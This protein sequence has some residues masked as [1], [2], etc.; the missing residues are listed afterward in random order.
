MIH[1]YKAMVHITST[2][3]CPIIIKFLKCKIG[4][5]RIVQQIMVNI[6][7][8]RPRSESTGFIIHHRKRWKLSMRITDLFIHDLPSIHVGYLGPTFTLVRVG[9]VVPGIRGDLGIVNFEESLIVP[10]PYTEELLGH[11]IRL[12]VRGVNPSGDCVWGIPNK[13]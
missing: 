1:P 9:Q 11:S 10:R 4:R 3:T 12:Q 13:S 6:L 8:T 2:R 5:I 7:T